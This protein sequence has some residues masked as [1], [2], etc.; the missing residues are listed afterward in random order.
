MRPAAFSD[1]GPY[2]RQQAVDRVRRMLSNPSIRVME[3]T[4]AWLLE[5]LTLY[6]TRPDQ[7]YNLTDCI[8]M[9]TIRREGLPDVL[10]NEHP[11]TQEGFHILFP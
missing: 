7:E 9:E 2:L 11:V 1:M 6:E 3:I 5:G 8:S 4:R 10:T